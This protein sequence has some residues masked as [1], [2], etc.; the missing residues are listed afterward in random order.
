MKITDQEHLRRLF[1]VTCE[2]VG[3][4]GVGFNARSQKLALTLAERLLSMKYEEGSGS[5][6]TVVENLSHQFHSHSY[7]VSRKEAL[8]MQ[9]PINKDRDSTLE[10]LMWSL[11]LDIEEELEERRPFDPIS[12]LLNSAQGP[13]L[14]NDIPQLNL[15]QNASGPTYFNAG[16]DDVVNAAKTVQPIDF[17]V[18]DAI[19]ESGRLSHRG[20]TRGKI[21]ASR[22][23]D[24]NIRYN[25][26]VTFKGW[27][28]KHPVGVKS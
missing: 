3:S 12:E 20:V 9:L 2:E 22:Q 23:P 14:L 1:Q 25:A 27:E 21:M 5:N 8:S 10:G 16:I 11:W 26:L 15:P 19:I 7:P 28:K 13:T 24:L 4:L 17:Q 18:V 6:Q